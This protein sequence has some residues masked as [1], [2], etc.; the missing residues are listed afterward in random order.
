MKVIEKTIFEVDYN[1]LDK[2]INKFLKS[3][4]VNIQYEYIATEELGNY[5]SCFFKLFD[6]YYDELRYGREY[7]LTA[8]SS[9]DLR[10][11][12]YSILLWMCEEGVI[13]QG[14]YFVKV[15]W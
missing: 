13:E 14:E 8:V 15:D 2:A 7:I 1:D 4:G 5:A 11:T 12:T 6:S 3:K 9:H 10:G